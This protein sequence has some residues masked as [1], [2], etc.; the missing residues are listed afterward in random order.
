MKLLKKLKTLCFGLFAAT[1]AFACVAL[2][3][4]SAPAAVDT[5]AETTTYLRVDKVTT[6]VDGMSSNRDLVTLIFNNPITDL[7]DQTVTGSFIDSETTETWVDYVKI[8]GKTIRES[9]SGYP[10][11]HDNVFWCTNN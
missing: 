5:N 11:A 9:I 6:A 8:N 1:L 10:W 2:L 7:T 4:Q 3:P